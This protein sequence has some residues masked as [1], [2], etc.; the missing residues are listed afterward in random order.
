MFWDNDALGS[1]CFGIR[2]LWDK[3]VL[4]KEGLW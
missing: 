3:G 2:M 1:R 4:G